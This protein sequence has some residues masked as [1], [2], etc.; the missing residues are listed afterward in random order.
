MNKYAELRQRQQEEF[1]ALPLGF[2]F[3]Q[4]QFNEMMEGW[5]LDPEK[6]LDNILRLPG[7][8]YVQKKDASLL[9]QTTERHDAEMAAAIA[10]DTT[11]EGFIYEMFLYELDNHEYGY[12]RDTEDTLDALGYTMEQVQ[13]DARL[14]RGFQRACTTI[15]GRG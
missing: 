1:N 14:L 5:G 13:A 8:G 4:K 2:A 11:G 15:M 10:E 6:D 3:S 7:G 9:H 12:T